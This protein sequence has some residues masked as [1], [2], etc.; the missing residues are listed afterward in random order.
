M[1]LS[2]TTQPQEVPVILSFS[3]NDPSGGMGI[4]ADIEASASMGC[5]CAPVV[6]TLTARDTHDLKAA[7]PCPAAFVVQQARAVLED[8]PVAVIKIGPLGSIDNIQALH[9]ILHDYPDIPVVLDPSLKPELYDSHLHDVIDAMVH[10]LIPHVTLCI[11]TKPELRLLSPGADSLDA[12][13]HQLMATG[14][15]YILVCGS[16][17]NASM[18]RNTL[19]NRFQIIRRF[20]WP[21]I[22]SEFFGSSCTLSA[23]LGSLLAQGLNPEHAANE[24]QAYTS[25]AMMRGYR[26]GMGRRIPNRLFWAQGEKDSQLQSAAKRED[27]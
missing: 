1:E 14:S 27:N 6:T 26:V 15:D 12:C 10:L 21:L 11:P 3:A 17:S 23:A 7:I 5:H 25:D 19:Y 18:T 9:S 8:M 24:A 16:E 4:Q 20:E 22:Q 2:M 13:A